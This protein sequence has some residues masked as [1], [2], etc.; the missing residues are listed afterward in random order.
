MW[1]IEE[2]NKFIQAVNNPKLKKPEDYFTPDD[3]A[4]F[5]A[6]AIKKYVG[7][8]K[9]LSLLDP[10]AWSWNL[11]YQIV[12]KLWK[13]KFSKIILNR[14][15]QKADDTNLYGKLRTELE[16]YTAEVIFSKKDINNL[17]TKA[18]IVVVNLDWKFLWKHSIIQG[19]TNWYCFM[20]DT[21][22]KSQV[23]S[24]SD[25]SLQAVV[26]LWEVWIWWRRYYLYVYKKESETKKS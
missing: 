4:Q 25:F 26:N 18:D 8:T 10:M 2:R 24:N 12:D 23:E 11:V 14:Y 19:L 6:L 13:G 20:L 15:N 3:V 16:N 1:Y 21:K 17:N 5:V 7:D 9:D 22:S